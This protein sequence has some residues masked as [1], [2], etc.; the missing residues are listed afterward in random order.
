LAHEKSIEHETCPNKQR[1]YWRKEIQAKY[2]KTLLYS[3][4][5]FIRN[6]VKILHK[7]TSKY[8]KN[9]NETYNNLETS[10]RKSLNDFI[11]KKD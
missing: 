6:K 3:E 1:K 5:I 7:G 11:F 10:L 9:K 2:F 8:L 4:K